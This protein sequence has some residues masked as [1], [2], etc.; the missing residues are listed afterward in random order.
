MSDRDELV[1]QIKS[2][3]DAWSAHDVDRILAESDGAGGGLGFGFR[4]KGVRVGGTAEEERQL[5][6]AWFGSLEHYRVEDVDMDCSTDGDIAT[7]WGFF[8]EDFAH[9]GQDPERVRVRFSMVLRRQGGQW[10][11]VWNHRDI[12]EFADDGFYVRKPIQSA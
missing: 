2:G 1:A 5:L 3:F 12:Q 8:T 9:I 11:P 6:T 4:T 10:L 7:V